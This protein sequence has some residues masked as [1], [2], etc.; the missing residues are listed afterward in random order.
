L[1]KYEG[2]KAT[3]SRIDDSIAAISGSNVLAEGKKR[4]LV[5]RI[6]SV[7][8]TI[9]GNRNKDWMRTEEGN[10]ILKDL[11]YNADE[12]LKSFKKLEEENNHLRELEDK[13]LSFRFIIRQLL[14]F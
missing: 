10:E 11:R 12:V 14:K 9:E 6:R 7:K 2:Y 13:I 8:S 1:E 4:E 5:S 3:I